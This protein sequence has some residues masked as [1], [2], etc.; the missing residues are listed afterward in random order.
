MGYK[1]DRY[2][3]NELHAAERDESRSARRELTEAQRAASCGHT[4]RQHGT[5]YECG[6]TADV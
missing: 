1:W 2:E 6:D 5:C 3:T 4:S